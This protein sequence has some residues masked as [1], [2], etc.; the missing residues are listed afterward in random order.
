MEMYSSS[1]RRGLRLDR[2]IKKQLYKYIQILRGPVNLKKG[3]LIEESEEKGEN[4]IRR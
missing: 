1:A 3:G 4:T 2:E